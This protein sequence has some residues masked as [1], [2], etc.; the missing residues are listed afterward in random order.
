MTEI[1]GYF[2]SCSNAAS[3]PKNGGVRCSTL[4]FSK[5][6]FFLLC[7]IR[8]SVRNSGDYFSIPQYLIFPTDVYCI[9]IYQHFYR[10]ENF[11]FCECHCL[12]LVMP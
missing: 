6:L 11:L 9:L 7:R 2:T 1:I 8:A 12:Y 10:F 3:P 4:Y 5:K